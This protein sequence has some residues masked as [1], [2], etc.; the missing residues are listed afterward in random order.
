MTRSS[1]NRLFPDY[2]ANCLTGIGKSDVL[3]VTTLVPVVKRLINIV[4]GFNNF[5]FGP[6]IAEQGAEAYRFDD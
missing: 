1:T 5:P 2:I 4:E 3:P 6:A